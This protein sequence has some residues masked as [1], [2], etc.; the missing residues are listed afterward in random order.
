[1]F[2][3]RALPTALAAPRGP[4]RLQLLLVLDARRAHEERPAFQ[5]PAQAL[6][7]PL[8]ARALLQAL[9]SLL[10]QLVVRVG[11]VAALT[12]ATKQHSPGPC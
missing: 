12:R 2:R 5:G 6:H 9:G 8:L 3:Q 11:D 7:R 10:P 1:M 4:H